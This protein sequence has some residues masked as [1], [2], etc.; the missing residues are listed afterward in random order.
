LPFIL[1]FVDELA[2]LMMLAAAET[3]YT[4]TRLAQMARAVGIHLI[5]ATQRPSTD[6]VTGLIKANF[7]ARISFAVASQ[8]DSRVILDQVG[9][10]SLLGQGDMLFLSPDAGHAVRVQGCFVSDREIEELVDFWRQEIS[11]EEPE[12]APWEAMI[13]A[14]AHLENDRDPLLEDA[15]EL[16][17]QVGGA[18]ASLLQRRM[19]VGYPRAAFIID[20]ME[21]LG[22]I[23]PAESG[24]R[25]R[26]LL[27]E[28]DA[29][30]QATVTSGPTVDAADAH[31]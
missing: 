18:S 20:Q 29:E 4:V 6:V 9:A 19:R 7:P 21:Q 2:D 10:E 5:M 25:L 26:Q 28:D 12:S 3:E 22:I 30:F 17:R 15:I 27:I 24:G 14:D 8:M 31:P 1:V 23:G 13:Q 11:D 16:V